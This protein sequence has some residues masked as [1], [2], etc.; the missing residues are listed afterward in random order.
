MSVLG[1]CTDACLCTAGLK[2]SDKYDG[3]PDHNEAFAW[4]RW[5]RVAEAHFRHGWED[6]GD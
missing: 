2:C 3:L 4:R 1:V 6:R 5:R